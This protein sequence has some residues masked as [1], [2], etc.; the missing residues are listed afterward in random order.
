MR[1]GHRFEDWFNKYGKGKE[2][3]SFADVMDGL[4]GQRLIMDPIGWGGAFFEC[5]LRS[6]ATRSYSSPAV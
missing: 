4:K 1:A 3:L 2:G 5:K 6:A